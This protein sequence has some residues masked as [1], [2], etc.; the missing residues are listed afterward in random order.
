[1]HCSPRIAA[2]SVKE[3]PLNLHEIR[4]PHTRLRRYYEKETEKAAF[5]DRIGDNRSQK[6][7]KFDPEADE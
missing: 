3:A 2:N 5:I 7:Q 6:P 1:M 4:G